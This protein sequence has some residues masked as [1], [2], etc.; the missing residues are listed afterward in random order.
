MVGLNCDEPSMIAWPAVSAGFD[1]FLAVPDETARSA[2]RALARAGIAAGETGAAGLAGL[3]EL[4]T[5]AAQECGA[6]LGLGP[7]SSALV[8]TTEGVTDPVA[9]RSIV[10]VNDRNGA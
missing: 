9:Y 8:L 7:G 2:M 6:Q 4:R 5:G 10:T 1:V 3:L